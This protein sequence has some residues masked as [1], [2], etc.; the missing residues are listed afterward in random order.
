MG[1]SSGT[2]P[3]D[4]EK[5]IPFSAHRRSG[6][7]GSQ[8]TASPYIVTAAIVRAIEL[9]LSLVQADPLERAYQRGDIID[10]GRQLMQSWADYCENGEQVGGNVV[11][12]RA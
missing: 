5:G 4:V 2:R 1:E 7:V 6:S 9:C 11:P 8:S 10:K 3:V 12:L